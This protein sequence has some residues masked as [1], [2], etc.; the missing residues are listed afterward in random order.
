MKNFACLAALAALASATD[1][2]WSID[3]ATRTF[4][5]ASGRARIFHGF[6]AVVKASPYLPLDD[7]FDF[8]MSISD[9]DLQ[10]L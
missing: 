4:R 8:D 7:H 9:E 2:K 5:D 3:S 6:N 1:A 10:Y